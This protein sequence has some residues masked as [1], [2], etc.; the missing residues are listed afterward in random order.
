MEHG[1]E[2]K[3]LDGLVAMLK[4]KDPEKLGLMCGARYAPEKEGEGLLEIDFF[5]RTF[6]VTVPRFMISEGP[7]K[8]AA[9]HM[10]ALVLYYLFTADGASLEHRWVALSEL[11]DGGFYN[12]AYQGYSG[13][14]LT[15]IFGNDVERLRTAAERTG[16]KPESMG[17]LGFLFTALP[18]VPLCLVY[19][20]GDEEFSPSAKVLFDRSASH[21][22]PTDLCAFLGSTLTEMLIKAAGR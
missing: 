12:N 8:E 18:R 4:K 5:D 2:S 6:T 13:N 7:S 21:Y 9:P 11:P 14:R 3:V 16:G 22:L 10:R 1:V 15:G 20:L 17:D 19:W